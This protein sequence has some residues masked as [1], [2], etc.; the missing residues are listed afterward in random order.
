MHSGDKCTRLQVIRVRGDFAATSSVI[1][2]RFSRAVSVRSTIGAPN[3]PDS[4]DRI[5]SDREAVEIISHE[6]NNKQMEKYNINVRK[7][8]GTIS[9]QLPFQF[10]M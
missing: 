7:I 6:N 3:A 2:V 5:P 1:F 9:F 4:G 10:F 8:A